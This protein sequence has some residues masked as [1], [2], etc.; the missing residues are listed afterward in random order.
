MAPWLRYL[1][2]F[3]VFCHGFIY[4]RIG[5]VLPAP[6][7]GW[8][9]RSWLLG[10]TITGAPLNALVVALHVGAGVAI[11]ACAAA[12]AFAPMVP[13]WWRPF[14]LSGAVMGIAAFAVFWDGQTQLWFD[15]GGIGAAASA[16]ML[17]AALLFPF[18]FP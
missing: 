12:L 13:G 15:E 17:V 8:N 7:P 18:A 10:S 3:V 4:I 2:A 6:V 1:I 14:A 16:V 11:L 5:S 9:G